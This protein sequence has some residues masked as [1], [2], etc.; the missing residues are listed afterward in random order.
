M[1]GSNMWED[2][3][4]ALPSPFLDSPVTYDFLTMSTLY[5]IIKRTQILNSYFC[6]SHIQSNKETSEA[7]GAKQ[8]NQLSHPAA[9]AGSGN[10]RR[11]WTGCLGSRVLASLC[12]FSR[13][14]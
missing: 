4:R 9:P 11:P 1:L 10:Q 3:V 13:K 6:Q 14:A 7:K 8:C 5:F 2:V 12:F